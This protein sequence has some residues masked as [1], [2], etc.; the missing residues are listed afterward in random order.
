MSNILVLKKAFTLRSKSSASLAQTQSTPQLLQTRKSILNRYTN[1]RL[2]NK[3]CKQK[4][5]IYNNKK[6]IIMGKLTNKI[7]IIINK[8]I[9]LFLKA[10]ITS[11]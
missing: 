1:T 4:G 10:I 5:P 7:K 3:L 9:N 2:R 8:F 11:Q 6:I